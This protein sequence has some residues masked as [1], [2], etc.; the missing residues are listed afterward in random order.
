MSENAGVAR[1]PVKLAIVTPMYGGACMAN[2]CVGMVDLGRQL[3][4][5]GVPFDFYTVS[6]ESLVQRARN[7]LL[8]WALKAPDITHILMVDADIGF[9]P[10]DVLRLLDLDVD[11]VC[12]AYSRK[13]IEWGRVRAAVQAGATNID[14]HAGSTFVHGMDGLVDV[15]RIRDQPLIEIRRAGTGFMLVR[16]SVFMTLT[17]SG[18]L[19]TYRNRQIL[20]SQEQVTQGDR[21]TAFFHCPLDSNEDDLISEDYY[22]CDSWRNTGGK[23]FLAPWVRLSHYGTWSFR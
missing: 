3:A 8:H 12:G 7:V 23:I 2:Y 20:L 9:E 19:D 15:S 14:E 22:F 13:H 1:Q 5:A 17:H 4:E 10:R 18:R 6:N 11:F 16:R 21:I